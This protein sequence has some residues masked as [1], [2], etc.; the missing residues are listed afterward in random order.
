MR[1]GNSL[2]AASTIG[3]LGSLEQQSQPL[4]V[5]VAGAGRAGL[6]EE[7]EESVGL[8][9]IDR[10]YERRAVGA[11]RSTSHHADL[12]SMLGMRL[13]TTTRTPA[14]DRTR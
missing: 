14:L 11:R 12:L 7:H 9:R 5:N 3:A 4:A 13:D 10:L 2:P 6:L 1:D 8:A